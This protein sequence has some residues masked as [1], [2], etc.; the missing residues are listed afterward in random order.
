MREIYE[1]REGNIWFAT[2]KGVQ[3]YDGYG[4][5]RV[6]KYT[7]DGELIKSWGRPGTGPG[8]FDL[9]HCVRVDKHDR[10]LVADRTNNQ[11]QFSDT[12]GNYLHEWTSL[13][14][15]RDRVHR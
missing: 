15:R 1:D 7:G 8:E 3:R 2:A 5:A 14:R 12:D 11:I 13:H 9:P 4:N 10:L 6:H